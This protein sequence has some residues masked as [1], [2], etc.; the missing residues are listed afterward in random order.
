M[1]YSTRKYITILL[2]IVSIIVVGAVAGFACG[3]ALSPTPTPNEQYLVFLHNSTTWDG[4][5]DQQL[6]DEGNYICRHVDTDPTAVAAKILSD[7]DQSR[8]FIFSAGARAYLCPLDST[9]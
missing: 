9:K 8:A 3:M 5:S 2:E 1:K 7:T 6:I 4:W